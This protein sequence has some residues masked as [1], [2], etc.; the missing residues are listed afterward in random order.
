MNEKQLFFNPFRMTSPE[1]NAEAHSLEDLHNQPISEPLPLQEGLLAIS[2]KVIEITR[3][4]SKCT[5]SGTQEQIDTCESMAQ[6]VHQQGK[7]LTSRMVSSN[8]GRDLLKGLIELPDSVDR[9]DDMLESI[10]NCYRIKTHDNVPFSDSAQAELDQL[11]A[12]VLDM[13]INIHDALETPSKLLLEHIISL[14]NKVSQ[15]LLDFGFANRERLEAGFCAPL[16]SSIYSD[17]L[18]SMKKINE[19][20]IKI[21]VT[22]LELGT[23]STAAASGP[24]PATEM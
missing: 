16:A 11:F 8:T 4:L 9:I 1:L 22:L 21:C 2:N 15:M 6:E 5:V 7:V 19:Y 20:L 3:L 13:M 24:E 17:L 10:L 23:V 18:D 14:G 12:F